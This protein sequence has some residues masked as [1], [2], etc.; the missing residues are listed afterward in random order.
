MEEYAKNDTHYLP[1]LAGNLSGELRALGRWEWFQQSCARAVEISKT[2]REKDVENAWRINGSS[3]LQGR[4]AALLRSLWR[5]RDQEARAVDRPAFH[6]LQND[7]LLES[8]R[9]FDERKPVSIPHLSS[10]RAK[11]FYAA[12]EFAL[13]EPEDQWPQPIRKARTRPTPEQDRLFQ[14]LKKQRDQQADEL[15]LDPSLIA[16]KATLESI[17]A[18]PAQACARLMRWQREL[19]APVLNSSS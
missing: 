17:A 18:D 11:R 13:G 3:D 19:L 5:W 6:I 8:A 7:R 16:P 14:Q 9:L 2:D 12:A 4:A 10:A 15:K 1:E